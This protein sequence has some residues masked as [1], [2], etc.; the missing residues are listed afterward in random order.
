MAEFLISGPYDIPFE[1][2]GGGRRLYYKDFWD[3]TADL[4]L[5]SDERGVYLF[6]VREGKGFTP[7]YI[8]SAT[9]SFRQE[10]FNQSNRHKYLD[11]LADYKKCS[12]VMFFVV[13]PKQ[14]GK[15]NIRE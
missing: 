13:H 5:I 4:K 7:L 2:A 1:H 6:G 11:G 8:G 15:T 9:K 10:C 12:P 3:Q 14:K